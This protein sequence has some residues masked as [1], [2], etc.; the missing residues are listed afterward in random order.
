VRA[1]GADHFFVDDDAIAQTVRR[2]WD[3]GV[4]KVLELL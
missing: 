3:G 1:S 2:V 4:D